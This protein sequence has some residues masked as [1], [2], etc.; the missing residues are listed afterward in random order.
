M[1]RQHWTIDRPNVYF[2]RSNSLWPDAATLELTLPGN[3]SM[4]EDEV[5]AAVAHP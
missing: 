3:M 5:R 4:N 2:D 1:G